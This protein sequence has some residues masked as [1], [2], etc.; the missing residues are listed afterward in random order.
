VTTIDVLI[1][2]DK[3]AGFVI[4]NQAPLDRWRD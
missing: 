2:N 4:I 1:K 3:R